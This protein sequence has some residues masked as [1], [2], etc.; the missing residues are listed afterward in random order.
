MKKGCI[1]ALVIVGILVIGCFG[2]LFFAV[3]KYGN[4]FMI[5]LVEQSIREYREL[6]PDR[7]VELGNQTWFK[8]LT[9]EN[10][11]I[12]TKAQ[13][14]QMFPNGEFV[15]IYQTPLKMV[16]KPNGSIVALSAGKDKKFETPDDE[17]S[18]SIVKLYQ[19]F[20]KK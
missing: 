8:A 16:Q 12:K 14:V 2:G 9:A 20:I 10:S 13:L 15:D 7:Q 5:A 17:T 19:K 6:Y 1:A 3:T 18:E 4:P 11:N